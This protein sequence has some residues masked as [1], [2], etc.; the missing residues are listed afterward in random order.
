MRPG[1]EV[2][3]IAPLDY[4][5]AL[6]CLAALALVVHG[7][8]VAATGGRA[9]ITALVVGTDGR[10]STS[11]LQATL[12]TFAIAFALLSLLIARKFASFSSGLQEEYLFLLGGPFAAAIAAKA[13]TDTKAATGTRSPLWTLKYWIRALSR[14]ET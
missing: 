1:T 13:I 3:T 2:A 8:A 4:A 5:L 14:S 7:L 10:T 9:G 11:K 12:W 6:A